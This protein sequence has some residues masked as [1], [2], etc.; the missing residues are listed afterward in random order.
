MLD[1]GTLCGKVS[2]HVPNQKEW[3]GISPV[4]SHRKGFD[5]MIRLPVA[6]RKFT[7]ALIASA[8]IHAALLSLL[9]SFAS[10]SAPG[11][12]QPVG[13]ICINAFLVPETFVAAGKAG[14]LPD[15]KPKQADRAAA[16]AAAP[17]RETPG[18]VAPAGKKGM[19]LLADIRSIAERFETGHDAG[20]TPASADPVPGGKDAS[21]SRDS[22]IS[23]FNR[24]SGEITRGRDTGN[25]ASQQEEMGTPK[26]GGIWPPKNAD[27]VP[28][29]GDNALPTYPPLARLRGYQG[30]AVLLVEVLADGRV[31]QVEISR[32]TG[33]EI[34]DRTALDTVRSW[35]FEPGRREGRPVAMSVAVPVRFV[36]KGNTMLV[37]TDARR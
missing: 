9:L 15:Q 11:H 21:E 23:A 12:V 16:M 13:E 31:G 37:K 35:K 2:P 27:A 7:L 14:A 10:G 30:V 19:M 4:R 24:G 6:E 20:A 25:I 1:M 18:Q 8:A 34:L 36:L 28:R 3:A 29:Y 32:S 26:G 33:H 22:D 17:A 5:K